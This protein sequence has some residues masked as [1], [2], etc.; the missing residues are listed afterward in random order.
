MSMMNVGQFLKKLIEKIIL[1][2]EKKCID[3]S[4]NNN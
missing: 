1:Y 3:F 4:K 2:F